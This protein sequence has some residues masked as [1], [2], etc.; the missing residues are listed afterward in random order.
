MEG[1]FIF[2]WSALL[3]W[4]LNSVAVRTALPVPGRK[5]FRGGPV[6]IWRGRALAG[7]GFLGLLPCR[8]SGSLPEL[9]RVKLTSSAQCF[10][11]RGSKGRTRVISW[12]VAHLRSLYSSRYTRRRR[13][14]CVPWE[15]G[16]GRQNPLPICLQGR[17]AKLEGPFPSLDHLCE[18]HLGSLPTGTG[19]PD[20]WDLSSSVTGGERG[21]LVRFSVAQLWA[22]FRAKCWLAVCLCEGSRCEMGVRT[23]CSA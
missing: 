19:W 5:C 15:L 1:F 9:D 23:I 11:G 3:L 6:G 8:E 4:H 13:L 14:S 17:E 7:S 20:L 21:S 18:S 16:V 10:T 2:L 12:H 22:F